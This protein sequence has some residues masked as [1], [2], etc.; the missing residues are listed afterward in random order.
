[1]ED[2]DTR[3]PDLIRGEIKAREWFILCD[4]PNARNS[5]WVQQEVELIRGM[6]GK[7]FEVVELGKDDWSAKIDRLS[8]RATEYLSSAGQ[9]AEIAQ[10]IR[11]ALKHHDYSF[12]IDAEVAP[13]DSFQNQIGQAIDDA[14]ERG[15]VLLLLSPSMIKSEWCRAE[16][17]YAFSL[18]NR[19]PRSNIIPVIVEPV[20][21][22]AYPSAIQLQFGV[23]QHFDLTTGDFDQRIET[24]I[25]SLKTRE[26]E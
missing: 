18:M 8:Q 19:N 1:M 10:R 9:D 11:N 2:N 15:F 20:P 17:E 22:D 4:S 6:E 24:L 12:W 5:D 21:A 13:E 7:V 23:L 25:R 3:L 14:L 26:M 16:V